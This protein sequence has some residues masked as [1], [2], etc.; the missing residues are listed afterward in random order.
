MDRTLQVEANTN[1][2]IKNLVEPSSLT[3]STAAVLVN[4]IFFKVNFVLFKILQ[5]TYLPLK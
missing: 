3:E 4:A 1:N 2:R 5:C